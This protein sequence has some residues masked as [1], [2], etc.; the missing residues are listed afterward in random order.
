M[1]K[2]LLFIVF[3]FLGNTSYSQIKLSKETNI[4]NNKLD[5]YYIEGEV[6][7]MRDTTVILAYYYGGKQYAQDT[8]KSIN[9]K[10]IFEG[11]KKLSGGMYLVVLPDGKYFDIIISEQK[12]NFSTEINS[13]VESMYFVESEENTPFYEYLN[14]I[15]SKQKE[16]NPL[17]QEQQNT[18]L[19]NIEKEK[20]KDLITNIDNDVRNY[21]SNFI[22]T[23]PNIFFTKIINATTEPEPIK[24]T[25]KSLSEQEIQ[26]IQ[27]EH[28]KNQ[29][30]E[31]IDFSDERIL[32]T[33][34]FFNKMD[35]YLNKLTIQHPDSIKKSADILIKYSLKNKD[36]FKYVVNH[37]TSTYERSKIMGMDAIFVHMVEN[38]YMTKMV[39]WIDEDQLEKI[40]ERAEKIAPNLIGRQAP[41]FIDQLGNPFM[42]DQ[43]NIIQ[44]LYDV[45]SEY[46][47]LVFYSPDCG[48]CKKT[49]P[50][51]KIVVDSLTKKPQLFSNH[52]P[53]DIKTYAVQTEFDREAWIEFI[54]EK[55]IYNWTNVCDIVED[56]DGNPAASSNWRDQYDIYSTPVIYLLDKDKKILAKR[57][58]HSQISKIISRY[59]NTN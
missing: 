16:V 21:K 14:Y 39:D 17:K 47:L 58:S 40:E 31:N 44:R 13:L 10:F 2:I 27:F 56:P 4:S 59:N 57:I 20:I 15:I 43:D 3:I 41:A 12:I 28:Y 19:S 9:G 30:W 37:I 18:N 8:A 6:K 22:D 25:D 36:I 33:P 48:H 35:M 26:I 55:D 5:F 50:K 29:F 53:I 42:R 7:G 38:Y 54:S 11:N 52:K 24:I 34:I 32:R 23:Y 46:T 1:K 49:I 51:I 45:K